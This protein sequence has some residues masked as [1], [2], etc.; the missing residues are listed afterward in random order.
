[1]TLDENR[2]T[3][4]GPNRLFILVKITG[5]SIQPERS[6]RDWDSASAV[7]LSAPGRCW[8]EMFKFLSRHHID[9][10]LA[11]AMSSCETVPLRLF[12]YDTAVVRWI[13]SSFETLDLFIG[14][15]FGCQCCR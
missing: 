9:N 8:A 6:L 1:M 2:S 12:I 14:K 15:G 5:F 13:L 7:I 10:S 3:V 11:R 4:I